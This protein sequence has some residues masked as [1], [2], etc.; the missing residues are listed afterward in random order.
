MLKA[1]L[2]IATLLS[3][4]V[5]V[6]IVGYS[7]YQ[8]KGE[9]QKVQ[10]EL[11]EI[12]GNAEI[13]SQKAAFLDEQ[14]K[15]SQTR[16]EALLKEKEA[17]TREQKKMEAQMRSALEDKEV[18]ISELQGRLTVN[19]VD[20]VLFDSGQAELKEEGQQVLAQIANVLAEHPNRQIY[21]IG[22][23]D[24]VPIRAS[25]FNRYSD[26]WEL[27]TGRATA[28][29]RFLAEKANIE[30]TRLAAVGYG[31]YHPIADNTSAEGR[32]RNRRIAIVIMPEHFNPLE[33]VEEAGK[34]TNEVEITSADDVAPAQEEPAKPRIPKEVL[35]P[36]EVRA[37]GNTNKLDEV[38]RKLQELRERRE[39]E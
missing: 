24:N 21:V 13:S 38:E 30:A 35:T 37:L 17:V 7:S 16:I 28:A 8:Q 32:A 15:E 36:D 14:L 10:Q 29:V 4:A 22:H 20:R 2:V 6:G 19:I 25:A 39:G 31:E 33:T 3:A 27:S 34:R 12:K 11:A 26:N 9:F 18:T 5:V 1:A 23:T